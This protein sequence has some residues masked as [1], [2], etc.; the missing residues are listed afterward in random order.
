MK[1]TRKAIMIWTILSLNVL[2]I[3]AA[4]KKRMILYGLL[5]AIF[6][7][8]VTGQAFQIQSDLSSQ[9]GVYYLHNFIS[10]AGFSAALWYALGISVVALIPALFLKG[11]RAHSQVRTILVFQPPPLFYWT[12]LAL[13][14]V[15][16][17]VLVFAVVG[18]HEFLHSSRP[19][20]HT[21]STIF[22]VMLYL[23]VAPL[24]LKIIYG[25][26]L[27]AGD[28][29]CFALSFLVTAAFSRIHLILYLTAILLA[30]FYASGWADRPL[31]VKLL[32]R[33][34]LF[35]GVAVVL[36][37][38]I[39]ALHDAQNFVSGSFG[40]LLAY[41]VAHPDKSILSVEYNYRVG[42][43]GMSGI[44]G[45][46]SQFRANPQLTHFDGGAS[47]LI[48]GSVQW[49]PGIIKNKAAA[50]THLSQDLTWYKGSVVA[51]GAES[52]FESYGWL[53]VVLYPLSIFVL[54]WYL[55]LRVLA[56]EM[57]PAIRLT[58][59]TLF[60]C[61]IFFVRGSLPVWIAFSFS[62]SVVIAV[63]WVFFRRY[64][65]HTSSYLLPNQ[66]IGL[67]RARLV[68]PM[69]RLR[70][71]FTLRQGRRDEE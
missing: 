41:I 7:F 39:G 9:H 46:F 61:C 4:F 58:A 23:G 10:D 6:V 56:S 28:I 34:L 19:G 55:P 68:H 35:G 31:S 60:A 37:F 43:E 30:F 70:K 53:G 49:L 62:Y 26:R 16:S 64:F 32:M 57:A 38:G 69:I 51:T 2:T 71:S 65:A 63:S 17:I 8:L 52:Y 13:L 27:V 20:Y 47:W 44:A 11:Y 3:L 42:V 1:W 14:S 50:L 15:L 21:G 33:I 5:N 59:Y 67:H 54:G 25:S 18:L 48:Q 36:F 40:D 12:L 45:A 22:I 24:L 66:D 29:A